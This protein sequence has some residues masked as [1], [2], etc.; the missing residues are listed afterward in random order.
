MYSEIQK[1]YGNKANEYI[2]IYIFYQGER[3]PLTVFRQKAK[4]EN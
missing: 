1:L 2:Y 3:A 4:S